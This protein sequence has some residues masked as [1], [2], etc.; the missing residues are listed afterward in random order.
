MRLDPPHPSRLP[1]RHGAAPDPPSPVTD[2]WNAEASWPPPRR[3]PLRPFST[4]CCCPAEA[5]V[6]AVMPA[7]D[8][9]AP[10]EL[11]L[12]THHHR[13][14]RAALGHAGAVVYDTRG[15]RLADQAPPSQH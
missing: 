4:A 9:R 7:R 6:Q 13:Q 15:V 10:V 11:L 1:S 3:P 8:G 5:T 2:A 12:C 14:S